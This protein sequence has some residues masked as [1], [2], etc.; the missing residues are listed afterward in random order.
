MQYIAQSNFIIN[1][2]R[3]L[4]LTDIDVQMTMDKIS[5]QQKVRVKQILGGWGIR[6][7]L[8][9]LSLH[10]GDT[11]LVKRNAAFGGPILIS[12]GNS[13]VAIGRALARRIIVTLPD[14][15]HTK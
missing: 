6:Q 2:S 5:P 10:I 1:Q 8:S 12:T 15:S 3:R 13:D 7:R 9:Q 4:M 14:D 11:V